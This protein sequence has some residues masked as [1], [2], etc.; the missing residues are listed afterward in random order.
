M[1]DRGARNLVLLVGSVWAGLFIFYGF[2]AWR[3]WLW[4]PLWVIRPT[5]QEIGPAPVAAGSRP[6]KPSVRHGRLVFRRF[7]CDVCHGLDGGGGV[8]NPNADP[9]ETVPNLFDLAE[10][11]TWNDLKEK[12]RQ[13]GHPAKL[14][15]EAA[16]PPLEMPGW[17]EKVAGEDLEDLVEFLFTLRA[18]EKPK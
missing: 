18:P 8:R 11:Y 14:K 7:H 10:A 5:T 16:D 4:S 17:R 2:L 12:I 1:K 3:A 6:E 15:E 13:G 9:D